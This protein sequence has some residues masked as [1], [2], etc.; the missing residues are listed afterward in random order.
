MVNG[1]FSLW[2]GLK[3]A[4][5][6]LPGLIALGL[7]GAVALALVSLIIPAGYQAEARIVVDPNVYQALPRNASREEVAS[8]LN[9]E[10]QRLETIAYSD[11]V[12]DG[13]VERIQGSGWSDPTIG[14]ERLQ[15]SVILPHPMEGEWRFIARHQDPGLATELAN[16]WAE[17]FVQK[18]NG[19]ISA[20]RKRRAVTELA[21]AY[22]TRIVQ[23]EDRCQQLRT[24]RLELERLQA[25]L[26]K[27]TSDP[28]ATM[29]R[30]WGVAAELHLGVEALPPL[31]EPPRPQGQFALVETALEIQTVE[32]ALC[33]STLSWLKSA[34]EGYVSQ[35]IS[36][37]GG[38]L[39][40]SPELEVALA[41]S[42]G[43]QPERIRRTGWYALLGMT[44]GITIWL[45]RAG[46]RVS[47]ARG[48]DSEGG[49]D[50]A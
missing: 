27:G 33:E 36:D 14:A 42:A 49:A 37:E 35:G 4:F 39:G 24:A 31:S 28:A 13:V 50:R 9:G 32:E 34:R 43:G 26:E 47:S 6:G 30:L 44:I 29:A 41:R 23:Q 7:S 25:E 21:D 45:I 38:T 11:A 48:V 15:E 17:T 16:A 19:A 18:V 46:F 22:A 8:Y 1:D 40:V 12:W 10:T 5:Y 2:H 3:G 20:A